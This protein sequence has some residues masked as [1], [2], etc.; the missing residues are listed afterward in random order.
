MSR[1]SRGGNGHVEASGSAR[2]AGSACRGRRRRIVVHRAGRHIDGRG[3]GLGATGRGE[4]QPPSC[5]GDRGGLSLPPGCCATVFADNLGHVR[6]MVVAPDGVLD[7]N[8]WSGWSGR[9]LSQRPPPPGGFPI[10]LQD[11][12]G[13]GKADVVRRF[14]PGVA[15]GSAGGTGIGLYN[16]ALDAEQNDKIVRYAL[17]A[18]SLVPTGRPQFV[19]SGLPLA[20]DPP[21]HPSIIDK[22]GHLV[23][24]VGS[25]TS[26]C[27][28]DNRLPN[29]AGHQSCTEPPMRAGLGGT[30]RTRPGSMSPRRSAARPGCAMAKV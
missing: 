20:G 24:D 14:G 3:S 11:R 17:T 5:R 25:A 29:S 26:A 30:T 7:V 16:G 8:R 2:A 27:Q 28:V 13:D 4:A 6:H 10:A 18:N 12:K 15:Q 9:L 22:Q 23:V 19:I 1:S 21:M